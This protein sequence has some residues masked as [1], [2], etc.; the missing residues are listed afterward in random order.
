MLC[1]KR[2]KAGSAENISEWIFFFLEGLLELAGKLDRK[3][4]QLHFQ[5]GYLNERRKRILDY[6][7]GE[8]MFKLRDAAGRFPDVSLNT[9][10]KDLREMSAQGVLEKTGKN[11]GTTY[12]LRAGGG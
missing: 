7:R 11:K 10:K 2:R 3:S 5:G 9:L 1:Q 12:R 8:G 4:A 6:A